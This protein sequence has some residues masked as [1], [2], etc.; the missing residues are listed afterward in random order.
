MAGLVLENPKPYWEAIV[1]LFSKWFK[2]WSEVYGQLVTAQH[3]DSV[4]KVYEYTMHYELAR[5]WVCQ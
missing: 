3:L 2:G 4:K 5:P 1:F